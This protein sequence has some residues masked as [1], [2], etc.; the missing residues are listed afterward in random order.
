MTLDELTDAMREYNRLVAPGSECTAWQ[1]YVQ[2]IWTIYGVS[3]WADGAES[4]HVSSQTARYWG[5][6]ARCESDDY[7]PTTGAASHYTEE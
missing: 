3:P 2:D 1:D 7:E 4:F 5:D 6:V